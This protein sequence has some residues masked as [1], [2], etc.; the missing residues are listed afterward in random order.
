MRKK[1]RAA[2]GPINLQQ[3]F[4]RSSSASRQILEQLVPSPTNRRVVAL[5]DG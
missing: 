5:Q 3:E 2:G 4:Y 1:C